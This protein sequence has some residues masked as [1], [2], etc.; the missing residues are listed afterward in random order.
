M[1]YHIDYVAGKISVDFSSIPIFFP[2]FEKSPVD[3]FI[4]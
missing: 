1:L 4:F 3:N 2:A